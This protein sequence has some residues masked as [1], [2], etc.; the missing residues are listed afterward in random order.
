MDEPRSRTKRLRL[1]AVAAAVVLALTACADAPTQELKDSPNATAEPDPLAQFYEQDF[2]WDDCEDQDDEEL[3]CGAVTV[4]V[5]Y[6]DPHG[7]TLEIA[8][9]ARGGGDNPY[10][11][12]NPGGP[13]VSGVDTV[14][15]DL[16]AI[17]TDE[18]LEGFTVVGFDPRGVHRSEGVECL[19]DEEYESSR[20]QVID[21][22]L[23]DDDAFAAAV[24]TAEQ[25]V[26]GCLQ[27]TGDLLGHVDTFSAAR[28]MNIIRTVLGEPQLHYVG[29]SYGTKLGMAYAE[30]FPEH[31]G[32]FVLDAM[33]DVSLPADEVV[34]AQAEGFEDALH[35][36][37]NW[38]V[39]ARCPVTGDPED[40]V[41]AV[42]ELFD[43]VAEN[44]R[45]GEDGR[46]INVSTVVSGFITP[47]YS[48]QGWPLLRDALDAAL[49]LDDFTAFQ[50]WADLQ[51]GR[52]DDGSYDW[53][54]TFAFQT[55][56]CLDYPTVSSQEQMTQQVEA[57]TQTAPTFGPYLGYGEVFCDAL[58]H[59]PRGEPW[60]PREDLPEMLFIGTTGDPAT[61]VGWAEDMHEMVPASALLIYEGEGHV[62]YRPGAD[63][64]TDEVDEFLLT[65]ELFEGRQDC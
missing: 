46:L 2:G 20:L 13:G 26:E 8:L 15:Q 43:D 14:T 42:A 6:A 24:E 25:L 44:P 11:L 62:A 60:E 21:G 39:E 19:S 56:A 61:P 16:P 59:E 5:D 22:D 36:F 64:V 53:I 18:L 58:P 52:N 38:C 10:L 41:D 12:I 63:C 3:R 51:A 4:P 31:V 7:G 1:L 37:A 40:V 23:D 28:D 54:S 9:A 49:T 48:P 27:R 55:I 30:E 33:L 50:Y 29:F 32:R 45:T 35:S 17:T 57:M 65:G 34:K 47:M